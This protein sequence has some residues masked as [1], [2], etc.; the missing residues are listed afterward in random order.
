MLKIGKYHNRHLVYRSKVI[1]HRL[2]P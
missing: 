1:N 2:I